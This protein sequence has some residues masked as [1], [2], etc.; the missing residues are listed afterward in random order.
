MTGSSPK[1]IGRQRAMA[2]VALIP[3][4]EP[5]IIPMATPTTMAASG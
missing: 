2:I 1:V 5:K 3:G 4:M